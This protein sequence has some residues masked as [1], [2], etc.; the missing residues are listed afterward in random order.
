MS[1]LL[2][3]FKGGMELN[4][5]LFSPKLADSGY[6]GLNLGRILATMKS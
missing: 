4:W 2:V 5:V 6:Q 3:I 1:K